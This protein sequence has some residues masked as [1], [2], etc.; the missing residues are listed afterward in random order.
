VFPLHQHKCARDPVETSTMKVM[1]RPEDV[2]AVGFH[3]SLLHAQIKCLTWPWNL[4]EGKLTE[5]WP[6]KTGTT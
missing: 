3:L 4:E 6:Y 2:I 1:D 5:Q